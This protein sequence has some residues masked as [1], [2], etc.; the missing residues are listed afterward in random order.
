M[1]ATDSSPGLRESGHA[2]TL[3]CRVVREPFDLQALLDAI[4]E[5]ALTRAA[6]A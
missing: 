2:H 4:M 6:N 3:Y 5:E 1:K